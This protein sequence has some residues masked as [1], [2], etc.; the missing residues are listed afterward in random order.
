M[1]FLKIKQPGLTVDFNGIQP[2]KTPTEINISKLDLNHVLI[3]LNKQGIN[4]FE[5][6]DKSSE[7][8]KNKIKT[9]EHK[10]K[11]QNKLNN[12]SNEKIREE[13]L[14]KKQ[15]MEKIESIEDLL[16]SLNETLNVYNIPLDKS[17]INEDYIKDSKDEI[18][19]DEEDFIPDINLGGMKIN[20]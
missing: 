16:L 1:L 5:I 17:K 20:N 13:D 15:L 14:N 3:E 11:I 10:P 9:K 7:E 8:I 12:T 19:E 4:D 6:K 2:R 18:E